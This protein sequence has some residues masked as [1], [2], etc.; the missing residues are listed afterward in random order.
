MKLKIIIIIFILYVLS[1]I[2]INYDINILYPY[3]LIKDLLMYPVNAIV[4]DGR[5]SLS[6]DFKEV[7]IKSLEEEI[8]KLKELNN[9]NDSWF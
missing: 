9:I 6:N 7:R 4:N 1:I 5:I 3:Y 2:S 8:E